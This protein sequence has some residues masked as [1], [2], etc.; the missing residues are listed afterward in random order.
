M[1]ASVSLAAGLIVAAGAAAVALE[2]RT[3]PD[4]DACYGFVG[5]IAVGHDGVVHRC[6]PRTA[7]GD[8]AVKIVQRDL[9]DPK[10]RADLEQE[11]AFLMAFAHDSDYAGVPRLFDLFQVDGR[12]HLVLQL[13]EGEVPGPGPGRR[14][15]APPIRLTTVCLGWRRRA[16]AR[17][18]GGSCS[19]CRAHTMPTAS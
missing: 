11:V 10:T 14:A 2:M 5:V 1:S 6:R 15:A 3:L 13:F 7:D 18:Q 12:P 4:P 16:R 8:V 9:A 17:N 19:I